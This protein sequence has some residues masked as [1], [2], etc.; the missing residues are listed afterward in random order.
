MLVFD[1]VWKSYAAAPALRGISIAVSQG[2]ALLITGP[3]GAGKSTML[4][5]LYCA[6]R[7]D[8]GEVYVAGRSLTRLDRSS[9]PYVRR[10]LG[11]VFQDFRLLGDRTALENVAVALDILGLSQKEQHLRATAMLAEVGLAERLHVRAR[12]LS[13]GEQQRV[14]LARA[15]VNEPQVVLADEPTGSL[16]PSR[17]EEVL[18]LLERAHHRGSTVV[19]ATHDPAVVAYG[20]KHGWRRAHLR[21]GELA[22]LDLPVGRPARLD[23][24]TLGYATRARADATLLGRGKRLSA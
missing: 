10:N 6:E 20:V 7:P 16:D 24:D 18:D 4:R 21:D 9:V 23:D 11:I 12:A 1:G 8:R 15:L 17:A 3:S 19:V 5:L 2:D 22:D 13:G 14:A